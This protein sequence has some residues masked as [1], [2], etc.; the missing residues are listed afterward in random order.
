MDDK[1]KLAK[2]NVSNLN[3]GAVLLCIGVLAILIALPAWLG[4]AGLAADGIGLILMA[5]IIATP[6]KK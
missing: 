2:K 1:D 4:W 6:S 3:T 5:C